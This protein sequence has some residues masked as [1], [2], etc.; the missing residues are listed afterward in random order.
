MSPYP[1]RNGQAADTVQSSKAAVVVAV[2]PANEKVVSISGGLSS[3]SKKELV[4]VL[5]SAAKFVQPVP[6]KEKEVVPVENVA[7]KQS[8][9]GVKHIE[10]I[11]AIQP[12][13][14]VQTIQSAPQ[15]VQTPSQSKTAQIVSPSYKA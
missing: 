9:G 8:T 3:G 10:A 7:V 13:Q 15:V 4:D 1:S 5:E 14:P 11:A 2:Q 12:T 6:Q